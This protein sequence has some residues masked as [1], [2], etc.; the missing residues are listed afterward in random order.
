MPCSRRFL[1]L[2]LALC[3]AFAPLGAGRGE[4][5]ADELTEQG[6][7]LSPG[8]ELIALADVSLHR[9]SIVAGS[10][11]SVTK[12]LFRS[13][14]LEG[15]AVALKDGHVVRLRLAAVRSFFRIAED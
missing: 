6:R 8:V 7:E 3:S 15:V 11:V 10:R 13:G 14:R 2:G 1:A 4:A 9:A 5:R 12:L